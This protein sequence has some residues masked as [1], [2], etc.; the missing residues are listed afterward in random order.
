MPNASTSHLLHVDLTS[1]PHRL[2][3]DLTSTCHRPHI[4]PTSTSHH[5]VL[6]KQ[7]TTNNNLTFLACLA[8]LVRLASKLAPY[9]S[10]PRPTPNRAYIDL[11]VS[12]C[13]A[14]V[15]LL[16]SFSI[17]SV[18]HKGQKRKLLLTGGGTVYKVKRSKME[19]NVKA[20]QYV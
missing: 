14:S 2:P 13:Q 3:I 4:D 15:K 5:M 16:S 20:G 6:C 7:C 9:W 19:N 17:K 11:T 18:E 10:A 8:F 12:F 1:T